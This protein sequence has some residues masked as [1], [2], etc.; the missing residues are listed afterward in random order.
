MNRVDVAFSMLDVPSASIYV[1]R[2][3]IGGAF[4]ITNVTVRDSTTFGFT[5]DVHF[6]D[7]LIQA[8]GIGINNSRYPD[9]YEGETPAT[10][11]N[12]KVN[13]WLKAQYEEVG[14]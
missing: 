4:N 10:V 12:E 8:H 5:F 2:E 1:N 3:H 13:E 7:C 6:N 9:W 11:V 14:E